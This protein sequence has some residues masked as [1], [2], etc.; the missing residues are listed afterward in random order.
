MFVFAKRESKEEHV[1]RKQ[2]KIQIKV[3]FFG[4]M[5]IHDL[6][7]VR[8]CPTCHDPDPPDLPGPGSAR[9][10]QLSVSALTLQQMYGTINGAC[11]FG[12]GSTHLWKQ[13]VSGGW[14]IKQKHERT[15]RPCR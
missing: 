5:G 13:H 12:T 4:D 11:A 15:G 14:R 6:L 1:A 9:P 7:C 8:I 10:V 2:Q 3:D